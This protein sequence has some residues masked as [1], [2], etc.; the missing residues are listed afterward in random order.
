MTQPLLCIDDLSI[1]FQQGE[2]ITSVV[3]HVSLTLAPQQ[4]FA[5]VGES[6]SG[7]SVTALSILKLLP[8]KTTQ[9]RGEIYFQGNALLSA[10]ESALR[11]VRGNTIAM[12]F[13][14]PM[15]SL[16]PL[17]TIE[18]QLSESLQLHQH[19]PQFACRSEIIQYLDLVGFNHAK[20]RLKSYPHQLSGGERQRVMIAMAV[21]NRPSLLI[22]DE[23]TT[24]LDLSI[25]AQILD[26]LTQLKRDLNM[27]L[28]FITH[29]LNLVKRLADTV[30]VMKQGKIIEHNRCEALFHSP[31]QAYTQQ[32]IAADPAGRAVPLPPDAKPLL[33]VQQLNVSY[34][35]S[36]HWFK[37]AQKRV[38]NDVAF[39]IKKGETLGLVGGSG[40]GKSTISL[41]I[42][43]LISAS[44]CIALEHDRIDTLN[45]RQLRKQRHRMQIV[46]QDPYSSLNPRL[47]VGE[48]I[49]EGLSVLALS[50]AEKQ[51]RVADIMQEL[52]LDPAMVS[53]YPH[54]FSGGQ[55]QRIAIAR[56]L[57]LKPDLLILDEPTSSLDHS[58]QGH[59]LHL[60]KQLQQKYH[61]SYLFISHDLAVIRAMCHRVAVLNQGEI[62][63]I[64]LCET[65]FSQPAHPYTQKLI[66]LSGLHS[67]VVNEPPSPAR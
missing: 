26:L 6:G 40:S 65:L 52:A 7:K 32:L 61:L 39:T 62:V 33:N 9:Y 34:P 66:Q 21:L 42:L 25:Q 41:A 1:A 35:L 23:P 58:T 60:L 18:K 27:S 24:A 4:T 13:Q 12:I 49:S 48:S 57:I 31:K 38:V 64:N 50:R 45:K 67:T 37:K 47:T 14:D 59:I 30:A 46:F 63:E 15:M 19:L 28:L 16:N 51:Q 56:A 43:R 36:A 55:R 2:K 10:S 54:E 22:A 11:R 53:R 8:E 5:L 17:H 44:G 20:A 29:N 3:E